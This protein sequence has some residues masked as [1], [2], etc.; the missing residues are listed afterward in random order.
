[1]EDTAPYT[2]LLAG[3]DTGTPAIR[4]YLARNVP[5]HLIEVASS[6]IPPKDF[7]NDTHHSPD[8]VV[9]GSGL[10]QPL[11]AANH[12]R[13]HNPRAQIVFLV[14]TERMERFRA[15]LPFV[16]Q[17]S[18][19]WTAAAEESGDVVGAVILEAARVAR[20]RE[21]VISVFDRINTQIATT[22]A[23]GEAQRRERQMLLSER[24]M[25][26][27]LM[28][29][30]DPFFAIGLQGEIISSNDAASRLFVGH[31][32]GGVGQPVA[33]LFPDAVRAE[34]DRLLARARSG[35]IIQRYETLIAVGESV[36]RNAAISLAPVR[37]SEGP[38]VGYAITMRDI[39]EL[40]QAEKERQRLDK[41]ESQLQQ[42]QNIESLG[43]M[44]SSI[45]HEI[46]QP[47]AS[48]AASS[49]G[50]LRWLNRDS[51][52]LGEARTA[53]ERIVHEVD[54]AAKIISGIRSMVKKGGHEKVQLDLN[55]LVRE[56]LTL[57]QGEIRYNQI[58]LQTELF[59]KLPPISADR[60]QLQQVILNLVMNAVQAMASMAGRSRVLRVKSETRG[61]EEVVLTIEDSGI[62][63]A[64]ENIERIFEPFFTTKPNG[65]GM[66]LSICRSIVEAHGG[67]LSASPAQPHGSAFQV[68]LPLERLSQQ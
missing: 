38:V 5:L 29:A 59:T 61:A 41:I 15:S 22:A 21:E 26:T 45:A 8:V 66:G 23:L 34:L 40:R 52:D 13:Q 46:N 7:S 28:Q 51:P 30:P 32:N 56:V 60:V 47:L 62:G 33:L 35:E 39:T 58:V 44:A 53:I 27:V 18:D 65:M 63:I 31:A 12:L 24:F 17:L 19:A 50:A 68:A 37:D 57:A 6:E 67:R 11:A 42:R 25:A 49:S 20:R 1:V 54:R 43:Q 2:V 36:T 14:S 4:S 16:P 64:A 10:L 55:E 9:V 3:I 48:I